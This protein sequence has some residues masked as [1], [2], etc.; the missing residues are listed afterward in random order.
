M[1]REQIMGAS[2]ITN[3]RNRT[4]NTLAENVLM[5]KSSVLRLFVTLA[6]I[7]L[8]GTTLAESSNQKPLVA[9]LV[10]PSEVQCVA[11]DQGDIVATMSVTNRSERTVL[12]RVSGGRNVTIQGIFGTRTLKPIISSWM[13]TADQSEE[14]QASHI[15]LHRGETLNREIA[16]KLPA[17]VLAQPGFYKIQVSFEFVNHGPS[18]KA[19]PVDGHGR[20]NWGIFQIRECAESRD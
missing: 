16:L 7:L 5:H 17:E 1:I 9:L 20:T 11:T 3:E 4:K 19:S 15:K 13:S 2:R 14:G 10:M 8:S 6:S 18:S 12:L